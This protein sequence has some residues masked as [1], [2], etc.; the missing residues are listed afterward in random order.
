[1]RGSLECGIRDDGDEGR[2]RMGG[3]EGRRGG[4]GEEKGRGEGEAEVS[5]EIK[6]VG[7]DEV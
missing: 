2:W 4:E 6:M 1:M 3:K 7:D 5:K